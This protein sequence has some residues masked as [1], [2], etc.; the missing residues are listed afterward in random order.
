VEVKGL[1]LL[2]LALLAAG[3]VS[4]GRMELTIPFDPS[5]VSLEQ[6]G[7]FTAPSFTGMSLIEAEGQPRLPVMPARIALPTGCIATSVDVV[8][9]VYAAVPGRHRIAPAG[10]L[11]PFSFMGQAVPAAPDQHIYSRDGA[12][13]LQT[14]ELSSSGVVWG[15]PVAYVTVYP[16]R[17]N[18][19]TL[20]L[21]VLQYLS[22]SVEYEQ[23]PGAMLISR[24][25]ESSERDAM[26]LV[27][28][29]VVNPEGVS[30]SGAAMVAERDLEYGQ[31]VI[32]TDPMFQTQAGEIAAWKTAKGIPARVFTTLWIDGQ[33]STYDLQ[34][35]MRAFLADCRDEGADWVLIM[36][37][38]DIIACRDVYMSGYG[39][40]MYAPSDMYYSDINDTEID[41][42]DTDNDHIWA[43][44]TDNVD[45]H[46]D[47]WVGRASISSTAEADVFVGKIM[48]YEAVETTDYFETAPREMR[49]GYSTGVLWSSPYYSGAASAEIISGYLPSTEWE[50][51]KCYEE[52]GNTY[53]MT[54]D[55]INGGPHHVY[56]A[57]HGGPTLMY[58][59]YGSSYTVAHIMA[60]TNISSGNLPAIWNSIAC[61]IGEL[62]GYECCG[63]AW[64]ASPNG[65]GFGFFNSRYG[66]GHYGEPG[67]GPSERVCERF[68]WEHLV[69]GTI[70]LGQ[71][72]QISMDHF[73]PPSAHADSFEVDVLDMCIKEYNL[74]GDPEVRMWTEA[75][76]ELSASFPGTIDG[77]TMVTFTV[78]DGRAPVEGARVCIQK[79]DWQTGEIYQ[80]GITDAAGQVV[81]WAD[82]ETLGTI[83]VTVTAQNYYPWQ[84]TIEVVQLGTGEGTTPAPVL[85]LSRVT[86]CPASVSAA[87]GFSVPAQGMVSIEAYDLS[88]RVVSRV[89]QG[90]LAAGAHEM[91]WDLSGL[92][93]APLPSGIYW[94]RLS[95]QGGTAAAQAVVLR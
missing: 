28:R 14:C 69:N 17:W 50:E 93:G 39:E 58:T 18:P 16:V 68:Y 64:L 9:A 53:Q 89:F 1:I 33:Y 23:D 71:A 74:F 81:L 70:P 7:I 20:E 37:D 25:S 40:V 61:D 49:V 62:D 85:A 80:I 57:S 76:S 92:T 46:P 47:L 24:R 78:T 83:A 36:G 86:P 44:L 60:Q 90:E 59:S 30:P 73:A 32:I 15:I 55:M 2:S 41:C 26:D 6:D 11:V 65:G 4:A 67:Y 13:P 56:H 31:Y 42:W 48:A 21:E 29:M 27:S 19:A 77:N 35:D 54:I 3:T 5:S 51:E 38:D 12:F 94:L 72:H 66:W 87:I 52:N 91:L 10:P 8:D 75:A 45:Y 22:V 82:P 88:G 43:E 95:A 79:G 34:Q 84:G 63:D